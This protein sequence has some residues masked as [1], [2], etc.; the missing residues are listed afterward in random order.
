MAGN[1]V[2]AIALLAAINA[3]A[4]AT[5]HVDTN[6]VLVPVFVTDTH[7]RSITRLDRSAFR[8]FD[9]AAERPV[10]QFSAEDVPV[11][12]G[13][14]FDAS[15]S[16]RG[17]L[18]KSREAVTRFLETANPEDEFLLLSFQDRP[19]LAVPLT[20]DSRL[21]RERMQAMEPRGHTALL[22]AVYLALEQMKDARHQRR[23]IL[24]L[25]DGGDNESRFT[26]SELRT[27]MREAGV[28]IYALGIYDARET[29]FAEE[30]Q[31]GPSLLAA[32]TEP[33]GGRQIPV[34][35]L[36]ELPAAA[37]QIG[38]ELRNQYLLAYVAPQPDG[39]YHR[40]Q[41]KT[42]SR[43]LHISARPGYYAPA[44]PAQK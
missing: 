17:K 35:N 42:T 40:I 6:L 10:V 18:E 8:V 15:A 41:V 32:I 12:I 37:A 33:S 2:W 34:F 16:M 7:Q 30:E 23:A 26:V 11:S 9:G 21:I 39:K 4:A 27:T 1:H 29:F 43:G 13:I 20:Q 22:D 36:N 14:V 3:C 31:R 38:G 19:Q 28:W 5:L 25:S 44:S 24:I